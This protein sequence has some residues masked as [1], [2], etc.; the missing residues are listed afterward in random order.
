MPSFKPAYLIHG[1]DHG[2]IAERRARLR[3]LAE[4][5][6]GT[7]GVEV[8]EGDAAT[9]EQAAAALQAMT[10][11]L[12]RRFV[13]VE[14]VERWKAGDLEPLVQ[15]MQPPPPDTTIAFF[16][17]EE[18]RAKAPD[19]VHEIVKQAG[20]D[21]AAEQTVKPWELP[22]WVA[23]RG[24][25]LGLEFDRGA[26]SA[27]IRHVGDRQQRLVRELEKMELELGPGATV[28]EQTVD[29]L[30]ATSAERKVWTL[31]DAIV[32]GDDALAQ[33][34]LLE[35]RAQGER[36]P[37]LIWNV[38]KRLREA[39][40]IATRLTAGQSP[41]QVR[42]GL[43]MPTKAAERLIDDVSRR[44]KEGLRAALA[45]LAD[46]ERDSRGGGALSEDTAAVLAVTEAT[47]A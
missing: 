31:A 3:A 37:G 34:C 12:G 1:D 20:G 36:L 27:L 25:E 4:S 47:S 26:A 24:R 6:S 16:A 43:R 19:G 2:R 14:G 45:A 41:A 5:E 17:R 15:A 30:A 46:L 10:F 42:K 13:I 40:D 29:D 35:L 28:T 9:P 21:I 22:K 44:D 38:A 18:S 11:A 23:A 7:G 32:A 39:N 33:R 8:L